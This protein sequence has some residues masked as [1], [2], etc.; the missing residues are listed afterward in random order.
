MGD[1]SAE[2]KNG[3]RNIRSVVDYDQEFYRTIRCGTK[4]QVNIV[5][6]LKK[7]FI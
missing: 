4:A 3:I 5:F 7:I 2:Q 6:K 1:F